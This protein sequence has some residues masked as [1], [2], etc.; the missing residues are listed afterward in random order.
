MCIQSYILTG[1]CDGI[2]FSAN[3]NKRLSTDKGPKLASQKKE[4]MTLYIS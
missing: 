3:V 4:Q 1:S 2:N